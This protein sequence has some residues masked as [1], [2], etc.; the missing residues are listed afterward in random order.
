[1][2]FGSV[3]SIDATIVEVIF[4]RARQ[5]FFDFGFIRL[6]AMF[7]WQSCSA[8]VYSHRV[9]NMFT[10]DIGYEK[11]CVTEG[12]QTNRTSQKEYSCPGLSI[13]QNRSLQIALVQILDLC[14]SDLWTSK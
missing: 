11:E 1:M 13:Q 4:M 12:E 6:I 10:V 14:S 2:H 9:V 3:G 7:V 8:I 5:K